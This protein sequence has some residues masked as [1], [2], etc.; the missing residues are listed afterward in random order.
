MKIIVSLSIL[1]IAAEGYAQPQPIWWRLY[2]VDQQSEVFADIYHLADGGFITTGYRGEPVFGGDHFLLMK[3]D[4][5]G[6]IVWAEQYDP[7]GGRP[8]WVENVIEADNGDI[9]TTS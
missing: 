1:V 6:E 3:L 2:D 7:E 4:D 5:Q 8:G 9:V